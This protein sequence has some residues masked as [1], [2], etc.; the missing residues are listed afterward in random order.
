MVELRI[1]LGRPLDLCLRTIVTLPEV[2][3]V[4]QPVGSR[5]LQFWFT[6]D[7]PLAPWCLSRG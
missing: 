1:E 3:E 5:E 6:R 7:T 2:G 4:T